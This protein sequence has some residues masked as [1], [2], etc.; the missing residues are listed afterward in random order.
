[1]EEGHEAYMSTAEASRDPSAAYA[2]QQ[3]LLSNTTMPP[4]GNGTSTSTSSTAPVDMHA[5]YNPM[6]M[7]ASA[8]GADN[9]I[10]GEHEMPP[11]VIDA[12]AAAAAAPAMSAAAV[13]PASSMTTTSLPSVAPPTTTTTSS[14]NSTGYNRPSLLCFRKLEPRVLLK[15][16]EHHGLTAKA[17]ATT[18]ELAVL[19][20]RHFEREPVDED[21][22]LHSFFMSGM[23]A[24]N[25]LGNSREVTGA[26]AAAAAAALAEATAAVP[27][28]RAKGFQ[29]IGPGKHHF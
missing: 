11:A 15:Y 8:A 4:L 28:R 26:S 1:M 22:V 7:E 20:S 14:S 3:D 10:G 6:P 21:V 18:E 9:G 17:D 25:T 16:L 29:L 5:A 2:G 24:T 27:G 12:P 23:Q 13:L 19:V